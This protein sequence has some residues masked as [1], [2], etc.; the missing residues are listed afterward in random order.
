MNAIV[1]QKKN[2]C[3]CISYWLTTE[4]PTSTSKCLWN[5]SIDLCWEEAELFHKVVWNEVFAYHIF[6]YLLSWYLF[7]GKQTYFLQLVDFNDF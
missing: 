7:A 1:S 6:P 5:C 3:Y 2:K 4:M